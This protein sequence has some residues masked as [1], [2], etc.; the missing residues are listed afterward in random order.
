MG[1]GAALDA[2]EIVL[3]RLVLG[4]M[5][6][7]STRLP[8]RVGS[9]SNASLITRVRIHRATDTYDSSARTALAAPHSRGPTVPR[10]KEE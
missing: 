1:V 7:F 4:K 8:N 10:S 9:D 3:G 5:T 6:T 2:L